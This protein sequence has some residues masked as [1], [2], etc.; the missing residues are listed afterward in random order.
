VALKRQGSRPVVRLAILLASTLVLTACGKAARTPEEVAQRVLENKSWVEEARTC[1][2]DVMATEEPIHLDLSLGQCSGETIGRCLRF[3][4]MDHVRAC[5]WLAQELLRQQQEQASEIVF[6]RSCILGD[7][8]GCTNRAAFLRNANGDDPKVQSCT[9]RTFHQACEAKDAWAC[10]MYGH[11]FRNGDAVPRD[12]ARARHY[13]EMGCALS[14]SNTDPACESAQRA[15]S[16][17]DAAGADSA[18]PVN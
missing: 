15:I 11:A 8:S 12:E 9:T 3:C 13:F 1:P 17:I 7:A 10:T 2:A 14:D 18:P 6:Q 4:R 16:E 5:Y